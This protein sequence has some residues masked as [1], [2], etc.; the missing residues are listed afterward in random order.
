[1]GKKWDDLIYIEKE[2][3][4]VTADNLNKEKPL[5]YVIIYYAI[6][7]TSMLKMTARWLSELMNYINMS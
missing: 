2:I 6:D 1:M 5:V 3:Q 4:D 7:I